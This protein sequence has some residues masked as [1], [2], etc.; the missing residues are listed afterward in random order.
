MYQSHINSGS[1]HA[2]LYQ[3]MIPRVNSAPSQTSSLPTKSSMA[4]HADADII[5]SDAEFQHKQI[6]ENPTINEASI[7]KA[8]Q[9]QRQHSGVKTS[10]SQSI[11]GSVTYTAYQLSDS[12]NMIEELRNVGVTVLSLD[13]SST[14]AMTQYLNAVCSMKLGSESEETCILYTDQSGRLYN[15]V[16]SV[17][18]YKR[19]F[20]SQLFY[21]IDR[22]QYLPSSLI[23]HYQPF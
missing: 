3:G 13:S 4:E 10:D 20:S 17:S 23:T 19:F 15:V 8:V 12:M 18:K 1:H 5:I 14:D 16:L 22:I 21:T 2:P 6:Y 9:D 7:H 11:P